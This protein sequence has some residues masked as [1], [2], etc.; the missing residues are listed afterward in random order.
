M[1]N[2]SKA[3]GTRWESELRDYLIRLGFDARREALHG[4]KDEGDI[5]GIDDWTLEA[6][7]EKRI[8]LAK[9]MDELV[10]EMKNGRMRNGAVL[11]KRAR[12]SVGNAYA[13]M[14]LF[15]L[16]SVIAEVRSLR[17]Q[18]DELSGDAT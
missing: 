6:K 12:H 2:R 1:T 11:V 7:N 3:K 10:V 16:L 13:V 9:Y 8:T 15:L 14:P 17:R 18:L 5:F 4:N